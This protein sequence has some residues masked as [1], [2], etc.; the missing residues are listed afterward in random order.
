MF[1]SCGIPESERVEKPKKK[2]LFK[3][4]F[5]NERCLTRRELEAELLSQ[6]RCFTKTK[7]PSDYENLIKL[8]KKD[9]EDMKEAMNGIASDQVPTNM[10]LL[11]EMQMKQLSVK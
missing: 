7:R 6:E 3:K 11:W 10:K 1:L 9:A 4:C 2:K 5:I 8:E